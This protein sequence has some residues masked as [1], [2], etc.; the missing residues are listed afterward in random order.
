MLA[1]YLMTMAKSFSDRTENFT[2][3]FLNYFKINYFLHL[4]FI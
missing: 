2:A 3:L 4:F 1:L